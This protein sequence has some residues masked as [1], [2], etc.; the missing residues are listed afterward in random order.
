MGQIPF[1]LSFASLAR[2][3]PEQVHD[4]VIILLRGESK[5]GKPRR[6]FSAPVSPQLQ[7]ETC[8]NLFVVLSQPSAQNLTTMLPAMCR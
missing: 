3:Q 2:L 7:Q 6:A 4:V 1:P 5:S 8:A